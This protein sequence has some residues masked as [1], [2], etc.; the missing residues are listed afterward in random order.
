M[1][2]GEGL[3]RVEPQ[4]LRGVG[5]ALRRT[6]VDVPYERCDRPCCQRLLQAGF[7]LRQR[8]F[9]LPPLGKQR[10]QNVRAERDSQDA[11]ASGKHA[12]R[13]RETGIAE[14]TDTDRCRPD[15]GQRDNEGRRR[16]E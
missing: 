2:R 5:A 3:P 10:G 16:R 15:D 9:V 12:V 6:G 4:D 1:A 8:G 7:A 13:H 11:A 14:V